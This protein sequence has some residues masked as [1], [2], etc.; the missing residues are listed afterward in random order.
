ML[1]HSIFVNPVTNL[2]IWN[3]LSRLSRKICWSLTSQLLNFMQFGEMYDA[4]DV[5]LWILF[6]FIMCIHI[7]IACSVYCSKVHDTAW[8]F[9]LVVSI[10]SGPKYNTIKLWYNSNIFY[11][12]ILTKR[13]YR[14]NSLLNTLSYYVARSI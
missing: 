4:Q 8:F 3:D 14:L 11:R 7:L 5:L 13:L 6:N 9:Y 1:Y 2:S 12:W 10:P